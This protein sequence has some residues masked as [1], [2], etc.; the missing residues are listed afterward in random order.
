MIPAKNLKETFAIAGPGL[1]NF[2]NTSL[3]SGIVPFAFKPVVVKH[4]LK[5]KKTQLDTSVL[6]NFRPVPYF[7]NLIF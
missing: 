6:S 4:L 1:L 5:K 3:N 2:M 7:P